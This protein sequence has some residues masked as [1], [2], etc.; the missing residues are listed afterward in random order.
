[1]LSSFMLLGRVNYE[2]SGV[3][4]LLVAGLINENENCKEAPR[5]WVCCDHYFIVCGSQSLNNSLGQF[6]AFMHII[7]RF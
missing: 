5:P 2:L 1:M 4:L 7:L 3:L 6:V